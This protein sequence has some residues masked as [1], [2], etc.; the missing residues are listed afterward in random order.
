MASIKV[1]VNETRTQ[2]KNLRQTNELCDASLK[3]LRTE[4]NNISTYWTGNS[5]DAMKQALEKMIS[6]IQQLSDEINMSAADLEKIAKEFESIDTSL[7]E[8]FC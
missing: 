7:K 4:N 8:R 6:D 3:L 2:A 5:G 1:N